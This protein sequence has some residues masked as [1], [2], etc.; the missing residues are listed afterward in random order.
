MAEMESY[1]KFFEISSIETATTEEIE[2][3]LSKAIT[4]VID[5]MKK[6]D[7][8]SVNLLDYAYLYITANREGNYPLLFAIRDGIT[9]IMK[10]ET[11]L[12]NVQK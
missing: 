5:G 8:D 12:G 2:R 10:T 4:S 3:D 11:S 6:F 9:T 7:H 1:R